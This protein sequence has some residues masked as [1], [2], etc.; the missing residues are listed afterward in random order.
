MDY[1]L[2]ANADQIVESTMA[3]LLHMEKKTNNSRSSG[4]HKYHGLRSALS[5]IRGVGAVGEAEWSLYNGE[6]A[7]LYFVYHNFARKPC[8][9]E[10]LCPGRPGRVHI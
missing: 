1:L 8:R 5:A 6:C 2:G 3:A 9:P 7:T 10:S 4:V